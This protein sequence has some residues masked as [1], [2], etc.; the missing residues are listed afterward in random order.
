M[1][2]KHKKYLDFYDKY[3]SNYD[4]NKYEY[5]GLGIEN[6]SYL[7]F[8]KLSNLPKDFLINNQKRERYSVDYFKNYKTNNLCET[9]NKLNN[10]DMPVYINSYL[11]QNTDIY[12]EPINK[13]SKNLEPN[14]KFS[15]KTIDTYIKENSNLVTNLFKKYV[16]YDGDSIEFTTFNFYKTNVK[17]VISELL[18]I[19]NVYLEELNTI[20][21]KQGIFEHEIIYPKLNYGFVRYLSNMNNLGI[22]NNGTYHLNIT[23]PTALNHRMDIQNI[24]EF[25][26]VH[27]NAVRAIQWMEPFLIALY[28]TPDILHLLNKNYAGGSLRLMMSRYI[29]LLTYDSIEM[30]KGKK[31]NDL[32]YGDKNH[33][34]GELHNNSLYNPPI[35]IGYDINFNKFKKH[36]I[37]LRIFDYFPEEYLEDIFNFII[38]LCQIST[39]KYIKN[40]LDNKLLLN[41]AIECI[42][43]GS[44]AEVPYDLY[45]KL[46]KMFNMNTFY[47]NFTQ[48]Q[49]KTVLYVLNKIANHLYSKYKNMS[50]C[51]K[52]S[53]NMKP[54][55]FTN[56]NKIVKEEFKKLLH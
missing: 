50:I 44:D 15:G 23:L 47:L 20:L 42:K 25:N 3:D 33:Y 16:I 18:A 39:E 13:Y 40:P 21:Y 26:N 53:P 35:Q 22:C 6:E 27:S 30:D 34:F 29:G 10:V 55:I 5:W 37:E 17:D 31:L 4:D 52:M 14:P 28:G 45:Y 1:D 51:Q 41:F 38:L 11:L 43:K 36:G 2:N 24:N 54:V 12:G 49:P 46:K 56:Y 7:M 9:L 48:R 32:Y 19:K 8:N